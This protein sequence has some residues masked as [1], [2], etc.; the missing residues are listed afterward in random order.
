MSF[1][2]YKIEQISSSYSRSSNI[3]LKDFSELKST[4]L[5]FSFTPS[6]STNGCFSPTAIKITDLKYFTSAF[7]VGVSLSF[8]L[9]TS[10]SIKVFNVSVF[11]WLSG[12]RSF[13]YLYFGSLKKKYIPL[14]IS[15]LSVDLIN[16]RARSFF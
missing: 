2:S 13:Q 11:S 4:F 16:F 1:S 5:H 12:G 9:T 6:S 7:N 10:Q 15:K 14:S 8:E 3:S